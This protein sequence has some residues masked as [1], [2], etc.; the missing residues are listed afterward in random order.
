MASGSFYKR[1]NIRIGLML[2][3]F[4]LST[5]VALVYEVTGKQA[6][7]FTFIRRLTEIRTFC[8]QPE[9]QLVSWIV[10]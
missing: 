8:R 3:L 4:A 2:S 9:G 6:L 7:R 10:I 5:V 1:C